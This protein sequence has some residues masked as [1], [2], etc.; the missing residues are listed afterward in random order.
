MEMLSNVEA[1]STPVRTS[2]EETFDMVVPAMKVRD[3]RFSEVTR[4]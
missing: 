1:L 4:F 2:G 3:F